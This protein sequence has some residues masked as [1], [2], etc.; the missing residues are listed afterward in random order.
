MGAEV[1]IQARRREGAADDYS[2]Y[3]RFALQTLPPEDFP[4]PEL[5]HRFRRSPPTDLKRLIDK[6]RFAIS[7]EETRDHLNGIY[8][9]TRPRA[10][11]KPTL[12]GRCHR[13][14]SP[15]AGG[16]AIAGRCR[17]MPGI[18][19]PRKTVH[20]LHRLSP[21]IARRPVSVGVSTAKVRFEIGTITLT[22]KLIDGS[23]RTMPA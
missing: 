22:S 8:L 16:A 21:R 15:G 2:R 18:I 3:R 13:W 20:E 9:H 7:T 23:S 12:W 14:S 1:E 10:A 5:N 17:R 19:L 4:G 11:R 6:T